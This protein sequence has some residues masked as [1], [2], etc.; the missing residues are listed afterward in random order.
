MR[1]RGAAGR[2]RRHVRSRARRRTSSS[3]PRRAPRSAS[4]GCCSSSAGDPWQKRGRVVALGAR[5]PRAGGGRGRRGRR[6]SRRRR[7]RSS[8]TR[9][10]VTADTLEA[11]AAP[12]RELF[13]VLGAD[14][15]ANMAHVAAARRDPRPRHGRGRRA[16]RRRPRRAPGC[17]AGG[18]SG[19]SIPR[20]DISSTDLRDR[21]AAG[22]PIDGLVPAGRR[23]RHPR[24]AGSTLA[25]DDDLECPLLTAPAPDA[26]HRRAAVA[27][28]RRRRQEGRRRSSCSTSATSSRSPRAFVLVER[29][30][31]APGAHDRRRDR[32][33]AQARRRRRARAAS[34]VS[35]T[36]RWVL[37]DFGDVI[38]HVFLAETRAYYDLD[39]LWADAPGRRVGDRRRPR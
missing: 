33:G 32:A 11:L 21:L 15:V 18:S 30:Q 6:A 25:A 35:T 24:R 12:D 39:R 2:A 19:S 3:R 31:H 13:L 10:S 38:V 20:L 4:T 26:R 28:R 1:R 37:M 9:A 27:A 23:A 14:A 22:R 36:R 29:D 17:R 16:P 34:R 8:A 5:P 7:S